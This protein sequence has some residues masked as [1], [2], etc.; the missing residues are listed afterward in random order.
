MEKLYDTSVNSFKKYMERGLGRTFYILENSEDINIY[1]EI[2]LYGC[3]NNISYNLVFEGTRAYYVFCLMSYFDDT[4][5]FENRIFNKY[6]INLDNNTFK[7]LSD[8]LVLLYKD[9]KNKLAKELLEKSYS[10]LI[11]KVSFN[12][13]ELIKL[14]YICICLKQAGG[15][16]RVK[17]IILDIDKF[18]P[19]LIS[20]NDLGWFFNV[21]LDRY[22]N[23]SDYI[24]EN[25]TNIKLEDINSYSHKEINEKKDKE[26]QQ[27]ADKLLKEIKD[28]KVKYFFP[29]G[30][31]R[32]ADNLEKQKLVDYYFKEKD[33]DV[34]KKLLSTISKGDFPITFDILA[35]EFNQA[36]DELK[37]SIL[38]VIVSLNDIR[39]KD[40]GYS[41]L[42]NENYFYSGIEMIS[43]YYEAD[44]YN[45]FV[46][47]VKKVN[48]SYEDD[49]W[50]HIFFAICELFYE[51]KKILPNELLYFIYENTLCSYCRERYVRLL[52][53]RNLLTNQIIDECKDDCNYD[54]RKYVKR[55]KV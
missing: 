29:Y 51:S 36:C 38:D 42:E 47:Y 34:K 39:I 14:D 37:E 46:K 11:T 55:I 6:D 18:N 43:K 54:I 12:E 5:F 44:D 17:K 48:I 23:I 9:N 30:F 3:L 26:E 52:R 16:K 25:C 19:H 21:V 8:L 31:A 32:F 10:K 49:R 13:D 7:H 35:Q 2:I 45:N 20:S 24:K 22:K 33:I 53:K 28:E 15:L 40:Y 1:K 41:L 50:H 4:E 27:T